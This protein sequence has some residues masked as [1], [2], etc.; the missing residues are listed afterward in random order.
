[1]AQRPNHEILIGHLGYMSAGTHLL[2]ELF[3][4]SKFCEKHYDLTTRKEDARNI[5][6]NFEIRSYLINFIGQL[7]RFNIKC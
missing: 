2:Q 1:V 4:T 5:K 3:A 7:R 6:S